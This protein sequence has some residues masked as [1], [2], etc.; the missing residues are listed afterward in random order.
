MRC[1][2]CADDIGIGSMDKAFF[3]RRCLTLWDVEGG[4]LVRKKAKFIEGSGTNPFYIPFWTYGL[5][6]D[7]PI[8]R[9]EDFHGYIRHIA[10]PRSIDFVD[11]RPLTLFVMAASVKSEPHR[12]NLSKR[13]TYMQEP[14]SASEAKN[15]RIWGPTVGESA[16]RNYAKIV[17]VSTLS[18]SRKN[19]KDF[20][21]RIEIS[22]SEPILS[23]IPFREEGAYYREGRTKISISNKLIT[24][25]PKRLWP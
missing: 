20:V 6:V 23:F 24:E 4:K 22:L 8:G 13:F 3:C 11:N 2:K 5:V 1:P 18:E 16:A 14:L 12:L 21:S 17:F 19:S 9:I 15:G 25:V 10:F 7:T